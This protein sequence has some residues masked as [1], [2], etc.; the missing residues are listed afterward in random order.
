MISGTTRLVGLLADPVAHS[1]S[2]RMQNA[3][4]AEAGLDWAYV[5]LRVDAARL[6]D[7]LAGLVAL[8]FVGANV[9]IPHKEAVAARV[10]ELTAVA[11][12]AGSVNT[13]V[14]RDDGTL[15]GDSTDGAAITGALD[16]AGVAPGPALV[17][18]AGGAARAAVAALRAW[19]G[20]VTVV[21]RRPEAAEALAAALDV[22]AAAQVP[23]A[24]PPVVVN[25]TPLGGAS[26]PDAAPV[27]LYALSAAVS[28][29]DLAYRPDARQTPLVAAATGLGSVAVDG[30]E[31]L[32]RQGALAFTRW[33]GREAPLEVMRAA[34]LPIG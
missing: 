6:D 28:V 11:R 2:P 26:E 9:T 25:A 14:V 34:L 19:G 8:S 32:A 18:G 1:L 31:V 4:F 22:R 15:L 17:V 16:A 33:S 30:L 23:E 3:A 12:A 7:A 20:D 10:D 5:P 24:L 13:I 21:S 29:V 27:P